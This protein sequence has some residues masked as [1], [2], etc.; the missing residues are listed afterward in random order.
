MQPYLSEH[1]HDLALVYGAYIVAAGSPGP[2]NM[3][4]MGVAMHFGRHYGLMF[5]AGVITGSIFWAVLAALG[6]SVVLAS[7]AYAVTII[8]LAGGSYL[9]YL[10]WKSARSALSAEKQPQHLNETGPSGATLYVR[11]LMLHLTNPKAILAWL[12]IMSLGLQGA[13]GASALP[14]VVAGCAVLG[15]LIFGGYAVVFST[16]PMLHLYR[17][18]RRW[19]EATLALVFGYAGLRLLLARA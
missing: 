19:I 15:I 8:K 4:I 2:S 13:G 10:A 9:L 6:I 1:L 7:Y 3:A 11:G 12:A 18:A 5:A 16:A 17:R 14:A